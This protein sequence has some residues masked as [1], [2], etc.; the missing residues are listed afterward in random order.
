M[1]DAPNV[2]D[3]IHRHKIAVLKLLLKLDSNR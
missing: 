3:K 2:Y 1:P